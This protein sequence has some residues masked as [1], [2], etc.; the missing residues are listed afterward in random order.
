MMRPGEIHERQKEVPMSVL[1]ASQRLSSRG[2]RGAQR[3]LCVILT[4]A[5]AATMTILPS[6]KAIAATTTLKVPVTYGQTEARSMLKMINDFRA[7]NAQCWNE[8]N[9]A[10]VTYSELEPLTYDYAMEQVAMLRAAEIAV[11][12]GH[13]RPNGERC[14]TAFEGL[15]L[16]DWG[17][18][19]AAGVGSA[20]SRD[21]MFMAWRE[22]NEKYAGQG[23]RRNML[24]SRFATVGIGYV[25]CDGVGFWV[26]NF[27]GVNS[28]APATAADNSKR[29]VE[30][31]ADQA[32]LGRKKLSAASSTLS[33]HAG[34]SKALPALSLQVSVRDNWPYGVLPL[35]ASGAQWTSSKPS[36]ATVS[37]GKVVAN[38]VGTTQL[39]ATLD[40]ATTTVTVKVAPPAPALSS[41]KGAKKK[42]AVKWQKQAKSVSG[43]EVWVSTSKKFT[44]KTTVKKTVAKSKSSLTVSKLK[45]KKTYYVKVRTYYKDPVTKKVTNSSWSKVKSVKTK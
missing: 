20:G 10:L 30:V 33:F 42:L 31:E 29:L 9:T 2:T 28:D 21:S 25:R 12:Y 19:I 32:I 34:S 8:T 37:K 35:D 44:A 22:D 23:H 43:Y 17:E 7:S 1:P 13:T 6:G 26:Q 45:A 39:K 18:N 41:V 24:N 27:G 38:A 14:F 3:I 36:V 5:L 16:R 15:P 40:G 4:V 11:S